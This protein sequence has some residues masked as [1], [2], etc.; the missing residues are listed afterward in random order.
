MLVRLKTDSQATVPDTLS[1]PADLQLPERVARA[2][3]SSCVADVRLLGTGRTPVRRTDTDISK[4]D[5]HSSAQAVA[6]VLSGDHAS[7]GERILAAVQATRGAV[8]MDTNLGILLLAAPLVHALLT[9]VEGITLRERLTRV[10]AELDHNDAN[11]AWQAVCIADPDGAAEHPLA[12]TCHAAEL[13]LRQIMEAQA[14]SNRIAYQYAHD[15]TDIFAFALPRLRQARAKWQRSEW[16][17]AMV[18]L[19]LMARFPDSHVVQQH[20]MDTANSL[21]KRVAP[22]SEALWNAPH[23]AAHQPA[24]NT[25]YADLER[26]N[27]HPRTSADLAVA[28]LLAARLQLWVGQGP[29]ETTEPPAPSRLKPRS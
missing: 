26:A 13:S 29:G 18:Y 7:V 10:L 6:P 25:L 3:W 8:S 14:D 1:I 16:P 17:L 9:D 4:D 20:G 19:G 15:Y 22:L 23:P 11:L 24:L 12:L 21:R 27:V 28:T 2:V 5:Y